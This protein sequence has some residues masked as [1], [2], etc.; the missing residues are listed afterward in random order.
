MPILTSMIML[1][2]TS[3]STIGCNKKDDCPALT[4]ELQGMS[5]DDMED[6]LRS[7]DFTSVQITQM[8]LNRIRQIDQN[9]IALHAVIEIN[10]EALSIAK[11]R[12][13]ERDND[14]IRVQLHGIPILIKDKIETGDMM[15][16]TD[17]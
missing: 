7:G 16:T 1:A 14:Q 9:G 5:I 11:E 2:G 12:D 17:G 13:I 15:K 8:Y 10:P 3:N 6:R 4:F